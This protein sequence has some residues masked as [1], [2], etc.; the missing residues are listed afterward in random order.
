[1]LNILKTV[2]GP[3]M[4]DTRDPGADK[5]L[6]KVVGKLRQAAEIEQQFMCMYLYAAFSIQ[7]RYDNAQQV[8]PSLAQLEM[9]RRWAN[10]VYSVA[11]QEM[12]HLALVN[13]LL[14]SIGAA[15]YFARQNLVEKPLQDFHLGASPRRGGTEM[16]AAGQPSR[17]D[18]L[19]PIPHD[20]RFSK[21]DLDAVKRWTCME[22]PDCAT[23]AAN[24][25]EHFA[26]WCFARKSAQLATAEAIKPV[27]PGTIE[28][29]YG[30]LR[31]LFAQL[32]ATAFVNGAAAQVTIEQ[33][34]DIYVIPVT[35]H[36]TAYQAMDLITEQGEGISA[37]PTYPSHYRR[38]YDIVGEWE[39]NQP[40]PAAWDVQENATRDDIDDDY[41][42]RVF[43]LF[44]HA[45]ETLL[46]MLTGLYATKNQLPSA[47]PYFAPALGMEAFSPF[48]TMVIRSLAEVLVQ[49]RAKDGPGGKPTRVGPG[50]QISDALNAELRHPYADRKDGLAGQSLKPLFADIDSITSRVEEFSRQLLALIESHPVPPVVDASLT[51]WVQQ[52]MQYIH[53]NS[54]RIGINLR[55]IYQQNVFSALQTVGY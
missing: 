48:M 40:L 33:Q 38:F 15:P 9:T 23:L 21:L 51:G 31:T 11:R 6:A 18:D 14:R 52:R 24:D 2:R 1:M 16:L 10:I 26:A 30:E 4:T 50:F 44:N 35:D 22:A 54:H 36:A 45:Y 41:T 13:N 20:F 25:G 34:Y 29:L 32:P 8:C 43:D 46:I 19:I 53:A 7:K 39:Q 42:R 5:L 12:E 47:Y 49:L 17:C 28:E 27:Q 3:I 37:S 55:R